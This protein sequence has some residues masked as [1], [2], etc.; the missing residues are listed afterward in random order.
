MSE[1]CHVA[2]DVD[3]SEALWPIMI[4][5]HIVGHIDDSDPQGYR[6]RREAGGVTHVGPLRLY[7]S[8]A[9][10]D[11]QRWF[12]DPLNDRTPWTE[13]WLLELTD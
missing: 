7:P 10:T 12:D 11:F 2:D 8:D 4:G 6:A 5:P 13:L 1:K 3:S 9:L